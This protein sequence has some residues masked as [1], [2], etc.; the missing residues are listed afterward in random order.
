MA[1]ASQTSTGYTSKHCSK[2]RNKHC[3]FF[4]CKQCCNARPTL[5]KLCVTRR[6]TGS[7]QPQ[8]APPPV[9][10]AP[11]N[12]PLLPTSP[13]VPPPIQPAPQ[14]HVAPLQPVPETRVLETP[15]PLER[16]EPCTRAAKENSANSSPTRLQR[17]AG[18]LLEERVAAPRSDFASSGADISRKRAEG[19]QMSRNQC[20]IYIW[21]AVRLPAYPIRR[22]YSS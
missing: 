22:V 1:L 21:L 5:D 8:T 11:Q 7:L 14:S 18:P 9:H 20:S 12:V 19:L 3:T 15:P 4:L 10:P 13:P 16:P 6:D 2:S 17:S